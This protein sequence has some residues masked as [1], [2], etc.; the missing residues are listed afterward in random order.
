MIRRPPRSTLFPYTTLFR[1]LCESCAIVSIT[2]EVFC[3]ELTLK[4]ET[5]CSICRALRKYVRSSKQEI[6]CFDV[7]TTNWYSIRRT[8]ESKGRWSL[9]E[10]DARLGSAEVYLVSK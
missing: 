9:E 3:I 4:S 7:D 2:Q 5:A 6:P 1:S 8:E 10:T